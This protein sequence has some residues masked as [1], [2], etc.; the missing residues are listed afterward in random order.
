MR[1]FIPFT[2]E[3]PFKTN[4]SEITSISLEHNIQKT[5]DNGLSGSFIVSGDYRIAD[6]SVNTENFKFDLPFE[7]EMSDIYNI[8]NAVVDI[9]DF[10]YEIKN[11][12]N[13]EVNITLLI[14]KITERPLIEEKEEFE[15][16]EINERN[17][18]EES[19]TN[20]F[21]L[22]KEER[23]F[24]EEVKEECYEPEEPVTKKEVREDTVEQHEIPMLTEESKN[25]FTFTEEEVYATYKVYIVRDGDTVENILEKYQI[26]KEILSEYNDLE[27]IKIGDK[28]VIP[29]V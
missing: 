20:D 22:E 13:L 24:T 19:V 11:S 23:T 21:V 6:T 12:E 7:I 26:T 9:D 4:I 17:I 14:D 5:S 15:I 2:K 25:I 8:D 16:T 18:L 10:F 27:N 28:L 29:N 3:I 1:K